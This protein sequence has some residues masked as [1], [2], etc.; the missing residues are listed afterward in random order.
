MVV[1]DLPLPPKKKKN[2]NPHTNTFANLKKERKLDRD[3][4]K[5]QRKGHQLTK[6]AAGQSTALVVGERF[7][8][9]REKG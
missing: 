9:D 5:E 3:F 7:G 4:R 1:V 8:T 2:S 6:Q